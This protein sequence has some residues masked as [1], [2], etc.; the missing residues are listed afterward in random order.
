[1]VHWSFGASMLFLKEV[2]RQLSDKVF[3]EPCEAD[4]ITNITSELAS[5][6]E[7]SC[8]L[9]AIDETTREFL[10]PPSPVRTPIFYLLPK[11]HKANSPGRPIISGCSGPTENLSRYI[12]NF[13]QREVP[14]L[15]SYLKDTNHFFTN[16]TLN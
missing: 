6:L 10:K 8:K 4:E 12:D 7:S 11:I 1:M 3:Y 5:F 13:L 14:K 15:K 9:A 2:E 16:Y